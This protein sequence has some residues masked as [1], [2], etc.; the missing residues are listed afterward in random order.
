MADDIDETPAGSEVRTQIEEEEMRPV[1]KK[2]AFAFPLLALAVLVPVT[3][4]PGEAA[5]TLRA[6]CAEEHCCPEVGS[7]CGVLD[8]FKPHNYPN[9]VPCPT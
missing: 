5:L 1:V 8:D 2:G 7:I 3:Y 9:D 4:D 6:A